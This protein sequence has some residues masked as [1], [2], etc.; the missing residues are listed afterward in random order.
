MFTLFMENESR[1]HVQ[2]ADIQA[3]LGTQQ[4]DTGEVPH[5]NHE[6]LL[7]LL[8]CML[9]KEAM[10]EVAEVRNS[11]IF[12]FIHMHVHMHVSSIAM[13]IPTPQVHS[14]NLF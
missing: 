12:S 7:E 9:R 13:W 3:A 1:V 5:D 14:L 6:E 2:S 10:R 4:H 8:L 11:A